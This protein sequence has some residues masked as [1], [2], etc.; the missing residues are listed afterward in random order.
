V[1]LL[2]IDYKMKKAESKNYFTV[3][4]GFKCNNNCISCML[5]G[6]KDK[7]KP[8]TFNDFKYIVNKECKIYSGIILS[9]AEVTLNKDLIKF[10]SYAKLYF[11]N[12]R[13][14]TNG[15]M[16]SNEVYYKKL[17]DS[18]INEFYV[19]LNGHNIDIHDKI[20]QTSG[21]F[22]QTTNALKKLDDMNVKIM[23]NTVITNLNYK[24]LPDII[25]LVSRFKSIKEMEFWNYCPM[26]KIDTYNLIPKL[27]NVVPY[28]NKAIQLAD[29]FEISLKFK[30]F[31]ECILESKS[32]LLDNYQP[33]LYIDKL[34]WQKYKENT[35]NQCLYKEICSSIECKGLSLAYVKKYGWEENILQ[36]F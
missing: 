11:K 10:V 15:R 13:I 8:I 14:Q 7:L 30:Y 16:L 25:E 2:L 1:N 28:L 5:K 9:G 6:Y 29:K 33:K 26:N 31:P 32:Y 12:I 3:T 20:T 17:I 36:P 4:I 23:I 18:G 19:S 34:H 27:S 22:K 35:F 21:S 24:F